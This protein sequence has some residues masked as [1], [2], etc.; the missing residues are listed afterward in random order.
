M[1]LEPGESYVASEYN[2]SGLTYTNVIRMHPEGNVH[3]LRAFFDGVFQNKNL[4]IQTLYN[5]VG[6]TGGLL[7]SGYMGLNLKERSRIARLIERCI[8]KIEKNKD[9]YYA[10]RDEA[11]YRQSRYNNSEKWKIPEDTIEFM[12]GEEASKYREKILDVLIKEISNRNSE[13]SKIINLDRGFG[14]S[15]FGPMSL[16]SSDT[17]AYQDLMYAITEHQKIPT[18][19]TSLGQR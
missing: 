4:F 16:F 8:N 6:G 14:F 13:L 9:S 10:L 5:L 11:I 3:D 15:I 18:N 7:C 1:H 19:S 12:A 17:R 2:S